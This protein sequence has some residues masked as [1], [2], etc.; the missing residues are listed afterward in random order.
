MPRDLSTAPSGPLRFGERVLVLTVSLLATVVTVFWGF[1]AK[2]VCGGAPFDDAGRSEGF[3]SGP[4]GT[5]I[6]CYSDVMELWSTRGLGEHLMP[7][8]HG[9]IDAQGQLFGGVVEYPVLSG[10]LMWLSAGGTHTDVDFFVHSALVLAPFAFATTILL[11]L[12]TRWWVLLWAATPPLVLY[13]FHNWE[14]P[15]VFTSVAAIAIMAYGASVSPTTGLRRMPV[16]TTA[17][18]ATVML[19]IGFSLKIYPGLFVLPI[20][21]YVL[22]ARGRRARD[23]AGAAWVVVTAV[24]TVAV[25]QLPFMIAGFDG[26]K[27]ALDFQGQRRA[28]ITTNSIWYWGVRYLVGD[29]TPAY[30]TVVEIASPVAIALG[31]AAVVAIGWR[32]LRRDGVYPWLPVAAAMLAVFMLFHKVHSPQYTLWILPFFA[33]LRVPWPLIASYLVA[34]VALDVSVF[35]M[36]GMSPHDE[37]SA[38][39]WATGAV[40][41][42]TWAQ[43]L[44]LAVLIVWFA[45]A[46]VREPLASYLASRTPRPGPLTR[47]AAADGS[48]ARTWLGTPTCTRG[49]VTLRPITA[50]DAPALARLV[51]DADLPLYRWTGPIPRTDDAAAAWIDDATTTPSRVAFAVLH[52][53]RLVG[54]TSFYDVDVANRSLAIGYTF[55][56][57]AAMGTA[58][59]PTAKLL[60]LDHAFAE[61]GAARVVWHTHEAN[62]RSRA[63]IAKLGAEFE[64]L[65]RKHRRFRSPSNPESAP[66][67]WR[68]T[69]QFAMTDDDWPANREALVARITAASIS[70]P[71]SATDARP[72]Q[73]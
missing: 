71:E 65:L 58:V 29:E 69:A 39:Q 63:A 60:L 27:A 38:P 16:R 24:V 55:Y 45:R 6:P 33:L 41:V 73:A 46:Q 42:S 4:R 67:G 62:A 59:N 68:T 23:W 64:G 8:V 44:L 5:L 9:G 12:M 1:R 50:S 51:D 13:A 22:T 10:L 48:D 35:R 19:G 37:S 53:G 52:E 2:F 31:I 18:A 54:T 32:I 47:L 14:L 57:A 15:V 70:R 17:V 21:I 61:S 56:G 72:V 25:T 49:D 7:Y 11:A 34:D 3:P 36:L 40:I 26:W 20:A 66:T 43:A 30:D 28:D